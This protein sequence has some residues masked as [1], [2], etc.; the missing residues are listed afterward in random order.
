M[1]FSTHTKCGGNARGS[2]TKI[3]PNGLELCCIHCL[4]KTWKYEF[5]VFSGQSSSKSAVDRLRQQQLKNIQC[6]SEALQDSPIQAHDETVIYLLLERGV[7]RV[8]L[9]WLPGNRLKAS[10]WFSSVLQRDL[11]NM[12]VY[13]IIKHQ[14]IVLLSNKI[15]IFLKIRLAWLEFDAHTQRNKLGLK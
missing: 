10:G 1:R 8:W 2:P 14:L 12:A 4:Q 9:P 5:S 3:V 13:N 7:C 15:F 6:L 11:Q